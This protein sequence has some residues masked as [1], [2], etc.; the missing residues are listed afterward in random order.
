MF[1]SIKKHPTFFIAALTGV[2]TSIFASALAL[3]LPSGVI[4]APGPLEWNRGLILGLGFAALSVIGVNY[5]VSIYLFYRDRASAYVLN[6]TS[7]ILGLILL[8]KVASLFYF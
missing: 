5:A 7:A 6:F 8:M 1:S 4:S 2:I 3:T